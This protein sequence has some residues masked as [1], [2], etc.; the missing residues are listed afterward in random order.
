MKKFLLF[1][2]PLASCLAAASQRNDYWQQQL[3]YHINVTLNDSSHTLDGHV[4]INYKNNSPDTLSFIWFHCWPNAFKNDRTAFSDQLLE[5]G[6]TDFYFAREQSRGYMNRLDFKVSDL[7]A[8]TEDH[9]A[10]QDIIKLIL[11]NPLPPGAETTIETGFHVQLPDNFS[12]MGHLGQSYQVTQWFPKPAVYDKFG[13]HE[14]PYLDQGEFYSEFGSFDVRITV[15]VEY[16]VASTGE[17]IE[18]T[19]YGKYKTLRY[20]QDH[21]HDFAWFADKNFMVISD[22]VTINDR[23]VAI[24]IYFNKSN[25]DSWKN[26][27]SYLRK[28]LQSKSQWIGEY[29][30]NVMS[31]VEWPGKKD[32][33]GMEYPTITIISDPKND[34]QLESLINHETGHNWFY[35]I[36]G[37]NERKHPWMDEGMNSYYDKRY[38]DTYQKNDSNSSAYKQPAIIK[39]KMPDDPEQ[40]LLQTLMAAR[41]DQPIETSSE[42]FNNINYNL[43]AYTKTAA[44]LTLLEKELGTTLFDSMM[45]SYFNLWK[46][47]HPYPLDFKQHVER[48]TNRNMDGIFSLLA[49]TG[50]LEKNPAR[51]IKL[52]GFVNFKNTDQYHYIAIAPS[53]G[54]NVYDK[55]M[56][57]AFIHNYNLPLSKFRFFISPLYATG[58]KTINGLGKLSYTEYLGKN[59]NELNFSLTAARFSADDFTNENGQ[60]TKQPFTKIVPALRFSMNPANARSTISKY[61]QW[62]TFLISETAL[63]FSRNTTTQIT[64][65]SFPVRNRYL[66]QIRFVIENSRALYPYKFTWEAEHAKQFIRL[67]F[68]GHYFFNYAAGGGLQARFFAGKFLYTGDNTLSAQY[69]TDRFHLNMTGPKGYED[70]HYSNYFVGRNEFDGIWNQQIMTRDGAFKIRTDLLSNKIGKT[71]DWLTAINL[72]TDIPKQ[73]NPLSLLPVKIPVKVFADIGT[74]AEAWKKDAGTGKF[75]YDA[76]LQ[77]SLFKNMLNIYMPVLYSKVYRDYIKSTITEKR[78]TR[79]ISF[80]IDIQD[81]SWKKFFPQSFF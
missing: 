5:N 66:N 28:A 48:F 65:V 10:H 36:L 11:P 13:W 73:F 20:Q 19:E 70:Y 69:A 45:Q 33:G 37:S 34:K 53:Y 71:D 44:W 17:Q 57:G 79:N 27:L 80:S 24:K 14:M 35:G 64:T 9:P 56:L 15:P 4:Q 47:K 55:W 41:K 62:K 26:G 12:R 78:F 51:K 23:S 54:Y 49:K 46:F 68:T 75:L 72:N 31:V 6:R 61:I 74:Y 7:P 39:N 22:S 21:V 40:L 59:R 16:V 25:A 60:T 29:P 30:Y 43:V 81:F 63:A 76:G 77:I 8:E 32:Q 52:T 67:G 1:L 50:P 58:S 18:N 38:T 42:A 2:F 3:A